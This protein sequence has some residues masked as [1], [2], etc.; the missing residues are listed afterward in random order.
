MGASSFKATK[1]SNTLLVKKSLGAFDI[2]AKNT[3]IKSQT[4]QKEI[5]QLSNDQRRVIS[6]KIESYSHA[7][8]RKLALRATVTIALTAALIYLSIEAIQLL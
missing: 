4:P 5:P 7:N 8:Q 2:H 3:L 6:Q 1:R